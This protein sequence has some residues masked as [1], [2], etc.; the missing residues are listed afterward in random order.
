MDQGK[1]L[2]VRQALADE[3]QVSV[4][5]VS[6]QVVGPTWGGEI[7]QK[8]LTALAVFLA[9]LSIFLIIY[10][11]WRMAIAAIVALAHDILITIGVYSLLHFEVTPSTVIGLLTIL[12]Y[13]LYDT[14][15]VFDKVKENTRGILGQSRQTYSQAANLAVNQTLVRSINTT[16]VA[17]L[18]VGSI[19]LVGAVIL[20]AGTL[21][22]LSLAL[23]V[24]MAAGA[25]SSIFI[26][27]PVLCQ[28]MERQPQ[29]QALARRVASRGSAKTA[30]T[31]VV[32]GAAAGKGGGK[33][34]RKQASGKQAPAKQLAGKQTSGKKGSSDAAAKA[35]AGAGTD[36]L[37]SPESDGGDTRRGDLRRRRG[38]RRGRVERGRGRGRGERGRGPGS[39]RGGVGPGAGA[40]GR[41]PAEPAQAAVALEALTYL[42]TCRPRQVRA[43]LTGSPGPGRPVASGPE[44]CRWPRAGMSGGSPR[45][46]PDAR[47]SVGRGVIRTE[48]ARR[49]RT[50]TPRIQGG[51]RG[52]TA[53][54]ACPGDH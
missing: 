54:R 32:A 29:M 33:G 27:T 26:A 52:R 37:D 31:A 1:S 34:A 35:A 44:L 14:V 10:F 21:K 5:E 17:L 18:P 15:V 42:G 6:A 41:G 45:V 50:I 28:L 38:D 23:F 51:A 36:T 9:L 53:V 49:R 2:K 13:S 43:A 48:R 7:T 3:C 20:G 16:V 47:G 25:Y 22:D 19:L 30:G 24:G 11:D 39:E 46:G 12:G 40:P 4:D 8:A